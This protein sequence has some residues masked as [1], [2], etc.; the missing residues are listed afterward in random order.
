MSTL[1]EEYVN[2]P[3]SVSFVCLRRRIDWANFLLFE[4]EYV[5][6]KATQATR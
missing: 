1:Q 3:A 4:R 6:R 2:I 5:S